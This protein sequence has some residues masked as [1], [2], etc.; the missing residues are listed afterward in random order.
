[1]LLELLAS[2]IEKLS[3][4]LLEALYV[5]ADSRVMRQLLAVGR[6]YQGEQPGPVIVPLTQHDLAGMAGTTRPTVNQVLQR[7][8]TANIIAL[9]R[10][11]IEILDVEGLQ[12]RSGR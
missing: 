4:S 5:G 1:M 10:G 3:S 12:R 9:G 8:M 11:R 2:R 6:T 7:L